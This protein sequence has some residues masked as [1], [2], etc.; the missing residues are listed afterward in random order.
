MPEY[1]P[2]YRDSD[3]KISG[4]QNL[5]CEVDATAAV[6]LEILLAER[7]GCAIAEVLAGRRLIRR[8]RGQIHS[9]RPLNAGNQMAL[10]QDF[11]CRCRRLRPQ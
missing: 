2:Y 4:G 10:G 9:L 3:G 1:R 8:T 7:P 5:D 11:C 6:K